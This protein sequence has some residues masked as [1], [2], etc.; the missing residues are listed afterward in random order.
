MSERCAETIDSS[1]RGILL[2]GTGLAL[3]VMSLRQAYSQQ[4]RTPRKGGTL[5]LG[6]AGGGAH[7]S[8]DPRTYDDTVARNVGL[9]ICNQL[10]EISSDYRLVPELAESWE[11]G[12][13]ARTWTIDIR[14]GVQFHDGKVLD[15]ED[16]IYSVN[17]HRGD[18]TRSG[19]KNILN[20]IE[21]LRA[22]GKYRIVLTLHA[23]NADFIYAFTDYH[24]VIVP[25]GF[26]DFSRLVGTGGYR[27]ESFQPGVR[28]AVIR[29][30]NYWK[31]GRAHVDAVETTVINDA[32]ARVAALQSGDIDIINRID[33]KV[34]KFLIG[35]PGIEVVKSSAGLHWTF[36]GACNRAPTSNNDVRLALKYGFDRQQLINIM[37]NGTG[38]VG[39]DQPVAPFNP[40]FNSSLPP[41]QFDPDKARFH[42]RKAGI[43]SLDLDLHV[44][45]A[46]YPEITDMATLFAAS[47]KKAGINLQVKKSPADGYWSNVWMKVPF[48]VSVWLSRPIDQTMALIYRSGASWNESYWSNPKFDRLLAEAQASVDSAKR[49]ELYGE[50]QVILSDEG[51]S[52]IPVFADYLDGKRARVQGYEPSSVS[53]LC[54]DRAAE[55]VWLEG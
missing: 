24:L 22:D 51:P 30:E 42:L 21:E 37:F 27:L 54:G 45:D 3:S 20:A 23:P 40:Y 35:R 34:A 9:S 14:K 44:S 5:N 39:N 26:A 49:K 11:I 38:S 13:D 31:P 50:M 43:D 15:A 41:R 53:D 8:L 16:V 48:Y 28:A 25:N 29:N 6:L 17:L 52:V 12:R 55:R 7:D 2:A 10:V 1:R 18:K 36:I 33:R 32:T 47:S 4:V 46:A 19:A